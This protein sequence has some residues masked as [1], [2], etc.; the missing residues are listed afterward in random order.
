MVKSIPYLLKKYWKWSKND[1]F[2]FDRV[3]WNSY[4]TN[5]KQKG[6][7]MNYVEVKI[8]DLVQYTDEIDSAQFEGIGIIT[9]KREHHGG[10]WAYFPKVD[11]YGAILTQ[12][13]HGYTW[14]KI[15]S[16]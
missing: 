3:A 15:C 1:R 12:P 13:F 16:K 9:H 6:D 8:G 14:L 10:W 2:A 11:D 5:I 7:N 4:I